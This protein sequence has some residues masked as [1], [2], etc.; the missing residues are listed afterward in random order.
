MTEPP[1]VTSTSALSTSLD[2]TSVPKISAGQIGES[3]ETVNQAQAST[4]I[5][6]SS[7]IG[8]SQTNDTTGPVEIGPYLCTATIGLDTLLDVLYDYVQQTETTVYAN[9]LYIS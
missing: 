7:T 6:T 3:S 4:T 1:N 8:Q 9:L 2:T 5:Y